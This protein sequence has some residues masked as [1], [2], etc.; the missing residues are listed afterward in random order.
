MAQQPRHINR[1][2]ISIVLPSLLAIGLFIATIFAVILPSVEKNSMQ[3]KKTMIS[4][5]TNTVWSLI[6]EYHREELA[7]T[8]S[9][10]SARRLA[11]ERIGQIRYGDEYKDYFWII[12]REPVMVMHPYRPEL[13]GT[14]L[15]GYTDPGGKALFAEAAALVEKQGEGYVD[16]L[17][18]WKDDSARIVPKLSYVKG[19]DPWGWIVGTGIYLEDVRLEIGRLQ[20][21]LLRVVL[22]IALLILSIQLYIIRQSRKIELRRKEA[23]RNLRDS[24][25]KYKSLVEASR[26][27]TLLVLGDSINFA[28]LKF[29]ELSGYDSLG[30]KDLAPGELF[31]ESWENMIT[32]FED[33]KKSVSFESALL[34]H[35]GTRKEVVLTLSVIHIGSRTGCIITVREPSL[36][37]K[38]EQQSRILSDELRS[39]L[40]YFNQKLGDIGRP[41]VFTEGTGSIQEAAALMERKKTGIVLVRQ[42]GAVIGVLT[43][44]DLT[45]RVLLTGKNPGDPVAEVMSAP[46][47]ALP[48]GARIYEALLTMNNRGISHV[49]LKNPAGE[50]DKVTGK[51]ELFR[52]QQNAAE[53]LI[54]QIGKAESTSEMKIL[55]GRIPAICSL[56][57]ETG[58]RPHAINAL[59]TAVN[60]AIHQRVLELALESYGEPPAAFCFLVLGS[61]GRKEQTLATDQDNAIIYNTPAGDN[62]TAAGEYFLR[63]GDF[64]NHS[65]DEIG[66]ALC[67]GRVMAG[68]PEWTLPL[69][70]WKERTRHRM[71]DSAPRDVMESSIFYDF[72]AV[73]GD[74]ELAD[75]LREHIHQTATKNPA[76]FYHLAATVGKFRPGLGSSGNV[77]VKDP[78]TDRHLLDLKKV[79]FPLVSFLRL[80]SLRE[81]I[82]K[83]GSRE[84]AEALLA[85]KRIEQN[86]FDNITEAGD[87]LMELRL[88]LQTHA[89]RNNQQ[90]GNLLD[91]DSL[92]ELRLHQLKKILTLITEF[93]TRV[94]I[95]FKGSG[96]GG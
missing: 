93:Q 95:E 56:M 18:Q 61:E 38:M 16:Y 66:I 75:E 94:N 14:N 78:S 42:G 68:N 54:R 47:Y 26:E 10:D 24:R 43:H 57:L 50:I 39:G 69:Q 76:F 45:G 29:L 67:K 84:R 7:G 65:L 6:E 32:R 9:G 20:N 5:L 60:D 17:W 91:P 4:E 92:S 8:L 55:Y 28:N 49:A 86:E 33:P 31:D 21:R 82:K 35:D 71:E 85:C 34:C 73:Y 3:E 13:E 63:L 89:L 77:S 79:S 15:T 53:M 90:P 19:F 23:E 36:S 81:G 87:F 72:R 59:T 46:V 1:F 83:T 70:E 88:R 27:G 64:V 37:E 96:T 74:A 44:T 30:L 11:A 25:L 40:G 51:T 58:D 48:Y 22:V 80:Y 2:F 12:T 62:K 52:H 41:A